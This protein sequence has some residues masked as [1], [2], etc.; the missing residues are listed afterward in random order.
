[1]IWHP[2]LITMVNSLPYSFLIYFGKSIEIGWKITDFDSK[3]LKIELIDPYIFL[4]IRIRLEK[5][6]QNADF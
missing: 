6:Y 4:H 2:K 1:M 3:Y 5:L